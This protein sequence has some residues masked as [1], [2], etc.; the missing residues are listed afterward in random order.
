MTTQNDIDIIR[1]QA[2]C[3][4]HEIRNH[5]SICDVYSEIIKKHLVKNNIDNPAIENA[6]NCI[7]KAVKLIGNSLLDLKS[8]TNIV[9][10]IYDSKN[11]IQE[12]IDMSAVY[13]QDKDIKIS[14]ALKENIKIYVDGN[15]FQ[16]CIINIIKNAIEA[17]DK[18]GKI[19][20]FEDIVGNNLVISIANNGKAISEKVQ[21]TLFDDGFTTKKT[22]SGIGLYLC[23]QNLEAQ[24]GSIKLKSSDS[25]KT[26]FEISVPIK[27]L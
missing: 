17:I 15:K 25:K 13:I 1:Q 27:N 4:G 20:I 6:L 9:P 10:Q 12:T 18:K 5:L 11:L 22:G 26:V 7:Q 14:S 23:K 21:T 24:N 16:A 8:V 2:R 3:I 19:E